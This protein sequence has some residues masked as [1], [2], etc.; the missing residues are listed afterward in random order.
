MIAVLTRSTTH[1]YVL[2]VASSTFITNAVHGLF[3]S[4]RRRAAGIP[5]PN[6]YATAEQA[7][8]DPK[9]HAFNCGMS[10]LP[11]PPPPPILLNTAVKPDKQVEEVGWF[12][13]VKTWGGA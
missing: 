9:A 1:S 8:K 4:A 12:C 13:S 7:A 2:A 3:T 11:S 6:P 5:Y 10:I